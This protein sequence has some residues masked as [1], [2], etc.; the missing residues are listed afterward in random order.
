MALAF[1]Y[2]RVG[3][4]VDSTLET[5]APAVSD[6]VMMI[7][8][9]V[10]AAVAAWA[11]PALS[12]RDRAHDEHTTRARVIRHVFALGP[13]E[14]TRERTGRIVSTATDAVERAAHLRN[15]FIGP[16]IASMTLPILVLIL[17]AI[18]IDGG[19]AWRLAIAVPAIPLA[20]G[21]FQMA[22]R[23]V[24][25]EHRKRSR[26]LAAQFLDAIQGLPTTSLVNA[27]HRVGETLAVAAES[28]RRQVMRLLAGS[29]SML[30]VV[31]TLFSLAFVVVATGLSLERITN[32]TISP[33]QALAVILL[34]TLLLEPLERIGQFF[35]IGMGGI[36]ASKEITTFLAEQP[37]V[38]DS[39]PASAQPSASASP[40]NDQ[41]PAPRPDR[42][43]ERAAAVSESAV[44]VSEPA[45]ALRDVFFAYDPAL[46]LLAGANLTVEK[47]EHVALVGPSGTGKSTVLALLQSDLRPTTGQVVV[48][49]IDVATE[50]RAQARSRLAVVNQHTYLFTGTVRENLRLAR[51]DA[52]DAEML[53]ALEAVGLQGQGGGSSVGLDTPVGGHGLALSGGEAQRIGIARAFLRES[54]ILLLDEPTAHVDVTSEHIILQALRRLGQGRT[55]L[56]VS[57]RAA[58]IAD[59][60]RVLTLSGGRVHDSADHDSVSPVSSDGEA[61]QPPSRPTAEVPVDDPT[62]PDLSWRSDPSEILGGEAR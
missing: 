4:I 61:F 33:G 29:Q 24:S 22:F 5:G 31:D 34:S 46:P 60:D 26:A 13:A 36:A 9:A 44:G 35:Y 17:I 7:A 40:R 48:A 51:P 11:E 10:V 15:G 42:A 28:S 25:R 47:G 57:H 55:V 12:S 30:F 3:A 50:L 49:G 62:G 16:M 23:R 43:S 54:P 58:T 14:R 19:I 32:D 37:A 8:V 56:A 21:L 1:I 27:E 45:L 6:I 38:G 20:L 52:S 39:T 18:T 53:A 41:D 59:A 2:L